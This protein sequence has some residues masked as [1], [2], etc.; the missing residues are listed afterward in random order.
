MV[1]IAAFLR[2]RGRLGGLVLSEVGGDL[3]A[4]A[5]ALGKH[6]QGLLASLADCF[7]DMT[8]CPSSEPIFNA[9]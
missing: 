7:Q 9:V 6:Y 1:E 8:E 4:A 2:A 5:C 3:E